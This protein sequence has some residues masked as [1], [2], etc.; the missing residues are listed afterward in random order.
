MFADNRQ[1]AEELYKA[2]LNALIGEKVFIDIPMNNQEAIDMCLKFETSYVFECA[3]MYYGHPKPL[4][5]PKIFGITTF[6]LG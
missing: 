1:I 6:E 2:C 4:P 3:R 5:I